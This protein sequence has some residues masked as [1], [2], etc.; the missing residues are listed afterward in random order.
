MIR[1][2]GYPSIQGVL[3]LPGGQMAV[4]KNI[5]GYIGVNNNIEVDKCLA[6]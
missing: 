2:F 4:S 3:G 5:P 1:K 6:E